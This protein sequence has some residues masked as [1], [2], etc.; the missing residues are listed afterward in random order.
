M[1]K[2]RLEEQV[3]PIKIAMDN[4]LSISQSDNKSFILNKL[5]EL[6]KL[7][8]IDGLRIADWIKKYNTQERDD[9]WIRECVALYV[10][11]KIFNTKKEIDHSTVWSDVRIGLCVMDYYNTHIKEVSTNFFNETTGT[12]LFEKIIPPEI[13]E[14]KSLKEFNKLINEYFKTTGNIILKRSTM[15]TNEVGKIDDAS[16]PYL[17]KLIVKRSKKEM[18]KEFDIM[19]HLYELNRDKDLFPKPVVNLKP[20]LHP[21]LVSRI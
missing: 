3:E 9:S 21:F 17:S 18:S 15:S 6:N 5:E 16:K 1:K 11:D 2:A 13:D 7:K 10:F 8:I 19:I 12:K 20:F 14:N 4:Y